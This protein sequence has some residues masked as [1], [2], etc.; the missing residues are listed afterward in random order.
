MYIHSFIECP[1]YEE[2]I[3]MKD[4]YLTLFPSNIY[5]T[6]IVGPYKDNDIYKLTIKRLSYATNH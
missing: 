2:G 4:N 1:T 6:T 3:R 5:D